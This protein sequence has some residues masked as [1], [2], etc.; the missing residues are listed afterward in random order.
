MAPGDARY[1][2]PLNVFFDV[3]HT[4]VSWDYQLRPHVHDVFEQILDDGHKIFIWSGMGVR[5]AFVEHF[6]LGH[7]IS[8]LYRK[9]VENHRETVHDF[10][11]IFPDYVVDDHPEVVAAFIGHKMQAPL[12]PVHEDRGMW[13]AYEAFATYLR[14]MA[15]RE[16][17]QAQERAAEEARD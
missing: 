14:R 6:K 1:H 3:D 17:R 4:L 8:G 12:Y 2:R 5:T 13:R 10:T 11:P 15:T 7:L 16:T 9:P